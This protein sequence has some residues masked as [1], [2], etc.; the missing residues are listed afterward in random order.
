MKELKRLDL[1]KSEWEI[2]GNNYY[3]QP[4][5]SAGRYKQYEKYSVA[6]GYGVDFETVYSTQA[7]I[8]NMLNDG[9]T[10]E[11]HAALYNLHTSMKNRIEDRANR[12]MKVC[13]VFILREDEDPAKFDEKIAKEKIKDW[14]EGGV[15]MNDFF[16]LAFNLVP[17]LLDALEKD[18]L[19]DSNSQSKKKK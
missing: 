9:K 19:K 3:L 12:A 1:N 11:G 4:N 7:T 8:I 15:A 2:N 5:I 6:F 16:R 18:S 14:E 17:G 10:V 13:S